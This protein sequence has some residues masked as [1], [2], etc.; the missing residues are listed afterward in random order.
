MPLSWFPMAL[1]QAQTSQAGRLG[2]LPPQYITPT[3]E[4]TF[5]QSLLI[6]SH[7]HSCSPCYFH[8]DCPFISI[9]IQ[10]I[11]SIEGNL[12]PFIKIFLD[13]PIFNDSFTLLVLRAVM[14]RIIGIWQL[15]YISS[16]IFDCLSK[17]SSINVISFL[18]RFQVL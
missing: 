6:H 17:I 12:T 4:I 5:P 7:L 18:A 13:Y 3:P 2:I 11:L 9:F 10:V 8:L 16:S 15:I 1:T 14:N